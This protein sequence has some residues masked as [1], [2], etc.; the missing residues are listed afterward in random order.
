MAYQMTIDEKSVF[1]KGNSRISLEIRNVSNLSDMQATHRT[2]PCGKRAL[3]YLLRNL[4]P[5]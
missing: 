2:P 1:Q 4:G 3:G 5:S